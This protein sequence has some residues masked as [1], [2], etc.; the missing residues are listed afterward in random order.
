MNNET[1]KKTTAFLLDLDSNRKI[2]ILEPKCRI[3]RD[4]LNDVVISDDTSIS[5][6]HGTITLENGQ[7]LVND[8]GSRNGTFLNGTQVVSPEVIR[9]GDMLKF[10]SA[11]FWVVVETD[12]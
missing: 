10:G 5:R 8:A 12:P 9:D 2:P 11:I 3:G 6:F 4:V 1:Q 7:H